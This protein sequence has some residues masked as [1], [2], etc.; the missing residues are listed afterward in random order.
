MKLVM[1]LVPHGEADLVDA[2]ISYHLNA[3][4]DFVIA[5]VPEP[6]DGTRDVLES[7]A[8]A[9]LLRLLREPSDLHES[10]PRTRMAQ[11]AATEHD[12]DWLISSRTD[13]FWWPRAESL[14][15]VLLP[16]PPRYTI[17]QALVREFVPSASDGGLFA[18]QMTVRRT[19]QTASDPP[20]SLE[21][22]LRPVFRADPG[23][24]VGP[25][26]T[27]GS[28]RRVP[29]RAWYPIEV[30][31]IPRGDAGSLSEEELSR[32]LSSGALVADTRL[33][34]ALRTLQ[35]DPGTTPSS[36]R[37]ALPEDGAS[38]LSLHSP[39]VVDDAAFAVECAEVGEVNLTILERHVDE[40]E[41]RIAWLEER[42]WPRVLRGLSRIARRPAP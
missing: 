37:F 2:Q 6:S 21:S 4:V 12:A 42:F 22:V 25:E 41:R 24:V 39:D 32:G 10:D 23:I 18:E 26:G 1:T 14:K 13:E 8:H 30:F 9:G 3:G 7:Y 40:L 36:S 17:V 34:D 19:L 38:R 15:D 20:K 35:A 16:I 5:F 28:V 31:R 33:R 29:L 27:G 11:L